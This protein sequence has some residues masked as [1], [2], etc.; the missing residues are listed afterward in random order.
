[1]QGCLESRALQGGEEFLSDYN[2]EPQSYRPTI[3]QQAGARKTLKGLPARVQTIDGMGEGVLP[4]HRNRNYTSLHT[5]TLFLSPLKIPYI[6][7]I[8]TPFPT[9][10]LFIVLL[11]PS[12]QVTSTL[13]CFVFV[14]I[15]DPLSLIS[16]ISM[17][18]KY[19]QP[20]H[21]GK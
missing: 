3:Y 10:I 11:I 12:S 19:Q 20:Q 1:M 14:I 16:L 17:I 6:L 15:C 21:R 9:L 8:F 13:K 7:T 2:Y 5:Y 4:H 18:I